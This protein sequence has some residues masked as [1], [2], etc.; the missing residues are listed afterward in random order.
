[1]QPQDRIRDKRTRNTFWIDDR[2]VDQFG[3]IF[4]RYPFGHAVLSVYA[5]LARRADRDGESWEKVR[6]MAA[7]AGTSERTFQRCIRLLELLE[8]VEIQS[9]FLE[10]TSVQTSNLYTLLTPPAE[11][12]DVDPDPKKWPA[13][14]R[15]VAYVSKGAN[16]RVVADARPTPRTG[17]LFDTPPGVYSTPPRR[18]IDTPPVSIRHPLEG[19]PSEGNPGKDGATDERSP[20]VI[21]EV[22]LTGR[23]VWAAA[24]GELARSGAVE[25]RELET[26][27]R[28]AALIGRDVDTLIVGAPNAVARDRIAARLLPAVR[29]ALTRT[30]GSELGVRVV[31]DG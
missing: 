9:C 3:P 29:A 10:N 19:F 15:A 26:W 8:L 27:L 1:M 22:G 24:L 28:P 16:R 6:S 17:C 30:V 7:L 23:Q 31:V 4:G 21:A 12:P 18:Q 20:F 2:L 25:R 11:P 14:V 5:V 13:A